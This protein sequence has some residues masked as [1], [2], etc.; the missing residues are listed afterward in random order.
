MVENRRGESALDNGT[1]GLSS[2]D[3]KRE[4]AS[5]YISVA[6]IQWEEELE[7]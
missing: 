6:W 3:Y 5:S 7:W 4:G 2:R 1:Q